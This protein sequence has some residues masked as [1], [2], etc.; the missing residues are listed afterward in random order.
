MQLPKK[1]LLCGNTYKIKYNKK[2]DGGSWNGNEIEVGTLDKKQILENLLHEIIEA[3]FAI[4]DMR[5]I[6]Q[7][8]EPGND[9]YIFVFTHKEFQLAVKDIAAA[10][11]KII[12]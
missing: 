6:R 2:H 12:K 11:K 3:I 4:R 10:L 1:I 5:Y 9:D 8:D 7:V